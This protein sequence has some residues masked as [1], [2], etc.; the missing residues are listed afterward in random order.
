MK[1]SVILSTVVLCLFPAFASS[2]DQAEPRFSRD[3]VP[4]EIYSML[5]TIAATSNDDLRLML[6]DEVVR[7]L[8]GFVAA[9]PASER[10]TQWHVSS[11]SDPIT[12]E[13]VVVFVTQS[14]T[15]GRSYLDPPGLVIR[16]RGS[17][18]EVYVNFRNYFSDDDTRVTYR[19]DEDRPATGRWNL[20]TDNT[21]LFLPTDAL[22][23]VNRLLDAGRLVVRATPY[24]ESPIT[25]TFNLRG[26]RDVAQDYAG[27]L[28]GWELAE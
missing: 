19:V 22:A 9:E 27:Q 21:A 20:S 23:F 14:E 25:A 2:Q 18:T 5:E 24:N 8:F 1:K 3:D 7:S 13:A 28:P 26:L 16:Q 11:D 6:Y 10:Y 15:G 4:A 17:R 12:D